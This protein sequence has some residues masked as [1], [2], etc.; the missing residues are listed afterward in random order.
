MPRSLACC[1]LLFA[2]G[3][4]GS[5][6]RERSPDAGKELTDVDGDGY[7]G[8]AAGMRKDCNDQDASIYPGAT[9]ICGD[10]IDQDCSGEDL[11]CSDVDGDGDGYTPNT[12]DCDDED[13][14]VHPRTREIT[15]N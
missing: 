11:A 1:V 5:G 8:G 6:S 4:G 3:C 15:Y 2:A 13:A 7:P 10:G 9:E 12:G 14:T